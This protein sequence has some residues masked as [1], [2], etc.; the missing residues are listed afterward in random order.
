MSRER[1]IVP[2][3]CIHTLEGHHHA[4]L[5]HP[6]IVRMDNDDISHAML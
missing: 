2:T 3:H 5:K 4:Q 6:G 1:W